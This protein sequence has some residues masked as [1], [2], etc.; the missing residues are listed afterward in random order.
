MCTD[1]VS[2]ITPS[3]SKITA[4]WRAGS[5]AALGITGHRTHDG[6]RAQQGH[7]ALSNGRAA[8]LRCGS[9]SSESCGSCLPISIPRDPWRLVETGYDARYTDR[10]ETVF[11][12]SNGYLGCRGTHDEGRPSLSPGVLVNG[13]H[14]TRPIV[15]AEEAYG[16]ARLGQTIVNVPDGSVIELSVDD[17]PL[18]LPS[19]RT[20]NYRR[21]LD[22]RAGTLVRDFVWSTPA[23]KHVRVRSCRLASLEHRHL[24]AVSYEV[25]LL[26]HPAPVVIS[27]Q[28][29]N[30]DAD[31]G[32]QRVPR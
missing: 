12:I 6:C 30:H 17:E 25:T 14:E 7:P 1:A 23:G 16:L 28:I 31:A 11:S 18:Y 10:A 27:S 9:C 32:K 29:V 19:A 20:W 13:F 24:M 3:R 5:I 26:D 15:H 22:M 21:E 4:S 2:V 8:A